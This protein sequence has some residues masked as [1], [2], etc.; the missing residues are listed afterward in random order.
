VIRVLDGIDAFFDQLA[1]V[2]PLP[3]VFAVLAQLA[4]LTC[5]SM[6]WRNVLA[7]AY[8]N[9]DV[10]RRSIVGAY[11]AGVGV[12]AI[13]PLRAETQCAA[14]S[15]AVWKLLRPSSGRWFSRLRVMPP[16]LSPGRHSPGPLQV[17]AAY[18]L[19]VST[20]RGSSIIPLRPSSCLALLVAASSSTSGSTARR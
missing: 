3:V 1:S 19:P 10:R 14:R 7:A 13:I 18:D 6:A 12:N 16:P 9:E 2:D 5:T 17:L 11:F 20:F 15:W 4:K 8:P